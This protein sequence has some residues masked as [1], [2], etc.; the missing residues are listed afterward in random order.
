MDEKE[1]EQKSVIPYSEPLWK[2]AVLLLSFTFESESWKDN[3][4]SKRVELCTRVV[5]HWTE[6]GSA[7][8]KFE[9]E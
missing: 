7:K 2:N 1:I 4:L 9:S 8:N 3:S 6:N 5:R